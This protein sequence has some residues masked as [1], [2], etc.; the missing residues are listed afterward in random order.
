MGILFTP[1]KYFEIKSDSDITEKIIQDILTENTERVQVRLRKLDITDYGWKKLNDE[2]FKIKPNIKLRLYAGTELDLTFLKNL[3]DLEN[4]S[5]ELHTVQNGAEIGHL[6][7]LK[8]FSLISNQT[9]FSFLNNLES[10][11]ET[12]FLATDERKYAKS[13]LSAILTFKQLKSLRIWR[14]NKSL[15]QIVTGLPELEELALTSVSGLKNINFIAEKQTL[16]KLQLNQ[17]GIDD[18]DPIK[19]LKNL[20]ALGLSRPAKLENL[21]FISEL[22]DLQ[23]LFLQTVNNPT[24]FPKIDNLHK[25]KRIVLYSVKSIS[26]FSNLSKET[27]L[28]EFAFYD[29]QGQKPED[30]L[31]IIT[32]NAIQK[33]YL[34]YFKSGLRN[35]VEQLL[36]KHNRQNEFVNYTNDVDIAY[37]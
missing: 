3:P 33:I 17:C 31:P 23:Y 22:T 37:E 12:L 21:D 6:K 32:N 30:F 8:N 9:D 2:I 15:E 10:P 4:L 35:E 20:K 7:K 27:P 28:K 5:L 14:Y 24:K 29:I 25:L 13:D 1:E 11:L 19:N 34:W 36:A 26:D 16:K 18:Y